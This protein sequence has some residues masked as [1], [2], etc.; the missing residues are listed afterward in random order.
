MAKSGN[1]NSGKPAKDRV[2]SNK[3]G[4]SPSRESAVLS[5]F[6]Y[7]DFRAYLRD[8]YEFKKASQRGYS[9]RA[10]SK[11]AGFSAP[12]TLK[13]VIEGQRNIGDGAMD[14]FVLGLGLKGAMAAYFAAL[15][16]MNQS[17]SDAEK[18]ACFRILQQLTP[19]A[20]RRDLHADEVTYLSHWLYPVLRE[21]VTLPEFREDP[22]W[23]A[24]RLVGAASVSEVTQAL[25]FLIDSGFVVRNGDRLIITDNMVFSS[26]ELRSLAI[27][28]YHRQMLDLAKHAI[29]TLDIAEREF[30]ALT[31]ILPE[32]AVPA[33]KERIKQFRRDLHSWAVHTITESTPESVV[34][35]NVQ[36]Y[37]VTRKVSGS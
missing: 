35:V 27:R 18:E 13:L 10:F 6:G 12:N 28:N 21:M 9:Y 30:G 29:D 23:I 34:Q 26:D 5:I 37:P 2:L 1:D 24:R 19:Q 3:A 25:R 17:K 14:Q 15:V 36:M 22:Y 32:T 33:L 8:F 16:Q 20:K 4:A 31:V 11:A 7:M